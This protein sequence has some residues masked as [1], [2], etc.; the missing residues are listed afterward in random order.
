MPTETISVAT[1]GT[2]TDQQVT[3][4]TTAPSIVSSLTQISQ[5]TTNA[6]VIVT[7]AQARTLANISPTTS[8]IETT[9]DFESSATGASSTFAVQTTSATD[10]TATA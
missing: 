5:S 1:D 10:T 9:S 7:S 6:T 8:L 2:S 4:E 3:E